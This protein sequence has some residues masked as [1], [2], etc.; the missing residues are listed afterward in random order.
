MYSKGHFETKL[1]YEVVKYISCTFLMILDISYVLRENLEKKFRFFFLIF[2]HF[3][4]Q[5]ETDG[6]TRAN[7]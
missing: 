5:C 6:I 1:F 2:F 4:K 7:I 3:F